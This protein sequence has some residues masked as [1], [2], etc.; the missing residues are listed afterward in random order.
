MGAYKV[1]IVDDEPALI[2]GLCKHIDWESTN[3][4]LVGKAYDG[5]EALSFIQNNHVDLLITDMR[6]PKMDGLTLLE[7]ASTFNPKL[8]FIIISAHDEFQYVKQALQY[9]IENYLVK[10]INQYELN[11]TLQKTLANLEQMDIKKDDLSS[12]ILAFKYNILNRWVSGSIE[13][14]ELYER[15]EILGINLSLPFYCV[16]LIDIHSSPNHNNKMETSSKLL[17]KI[18]AKI[19][20]NDNIPLF[21]D[22][23]FCIV[24]II[25]D[26]EINT[27]RLAT[28]E[29][30]KDIQ[31]ITRQNNI[32][33][34]VS[35]GNI[36][37]SS[38]NIHMSYNNCL[39]WQ[40]YKYLCH[41]ALT[42]DTNDFISEK[43]TKNT[44]LQNLLYNFNI[45][46][47]QNNA[48]M[49]MSYTSKYISKTC[50]QTTKCYEKKIILLPLLMNLIKTV[51][52]T[53]K[54]KEV[55]PDFFH[56]HL[57]HFSKIND[58]AILNQWIQE[59]LTNAISVMSKR[60]TSYHLLVHLT[61]EIINTRFN[62]Q[63]SLKAIANGFDVTPA[64]LGQL[65][66][67]ETGE[68]FNDYLTNIRMQA[69]RE[70]LSIGKLK[71][72][73]IVE[74]VGIVNQSYFN[75][76]FKKMHGISPTE[77]IRT[78]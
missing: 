41:N 55:L 18:R 57:A 74:K 52:A 51:Y 20:H 65:F 24:I 68:L 64:Y 38:E 33:A 36:V 56:A 66:K 1:L 63:L 50:K 9:G 76:I 14:F 29:F 67:S 61:L 70:L 72:N 22:T 11:A 15:A 71:I 21:I 77:F 78:K 60:V 47:Q 42:V 16:M 7:K 27:L 37:D 23:N 75:R 59:C 13:A 39:L 10:P 34:F 53:G 19:S 26:Y 8:K 58:E 5:L 4:A 49:A 3:M 30:V 25:C 73:E 17:N 54:N 46:I 62:E 35:I 28:E 45:S 40:N 69:A 31:N 6:M 48:Q 12:E 32:S 44:E 43:N 2:D